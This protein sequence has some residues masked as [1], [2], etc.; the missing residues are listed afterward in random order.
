MD[1]LRYDSCFPRESVDAEKMTD[2]PGERR[3]ARLI[4]LCT[5]Q[6][7]RHWMPSD[8]RWNSFMWKVVEVRHA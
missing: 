6:E 4:N 1:M 3:P 7:G 5:W 8:G 2:Y